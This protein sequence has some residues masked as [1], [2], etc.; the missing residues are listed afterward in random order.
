MILG[1][2]ISTSITGITILDTDGSVVYNNI[3]DTRKEKDFFDKVSKMKELLK[4]FQ[5]PSHFTSPITDIYIEESLQ[6]F[7][8]GKSSAA[9]LSKL[10]K[11]NGTV[12]WLLYEMF[13]VKPIGISAGT[14]RKLAGITIRRDGRKAKEQVMEHMINNEK[15]FVVEY[16]KQGNIKTHFYDLADSYVIARAGLTYS[17]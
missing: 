14:A 16:T 17:P 11:F 1:L 5:P 4:E 3:C 6:M 13:G 15:W 9:I 7:Q 2:D 10:T 8:S 12:Q